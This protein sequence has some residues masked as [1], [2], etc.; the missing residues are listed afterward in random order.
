MHAFAGLSIEIRAF[1]YSL[2]FMLSGKLRLS[3]VGNGGIIDLQVFFDIEIDSKPAG[4][5]VIGM[6]GK[7]SEPLL[8]RG[9]IP[10]AACGHWGSWRACPCVQVC[11]AP[12]AGRTPHGGQLCGALH[13]REGRWQ[14]GQ[15]SSLQ[16]LDLPPVREILLGDGIC[17]LAL[18]ATPLLHAA[19]S[20]SL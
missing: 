3:P 1:V 8:H 9:C 18:S 16:G 7:A 17:A 5:I 20:P 15:A 19:S 4:R 11:T 2:A 6:Y 14:E 12:P 13:W 10:V